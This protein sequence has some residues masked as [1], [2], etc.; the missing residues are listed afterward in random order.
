M[1]IENSPRRRLR[2]ERSP[3]AYLI[4]GS[5]IAIYG[6]GLLFD[7]LGFGEVRYYV[8]HA[9]P[10]ALVIIGIT[11]LIRRDENCNRYGFWGTVLIFGGLWAYAA[12]RGW[13]HVNFWAVFGPTMLV[14]LGASFVYRAL[15]RPRPDSD[16]G[17]YIHSFAIF[18]G[19]ELK[20]TTTPFSG[21]DLAALMGGVV[22]DL[23]NTQME[24]DSATIDV[25][26][27][28]GG[29][30]LFVPRDW[31]VTTKVM[32]FMGACVDKRRPATTP[33]TK[34]LI[35][36]GATFLGGIEIKD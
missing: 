22:L 15:Y 14:L 4:I 7:N 30:E 25:L 8:R 27:V 10:A 19:N 5:L 2:R 23:S 11:L 13:I 33:G 34:T 36:R 29:I 1:A 16:S 12:Q 32:S 21:A 20:P 31:N 17:S 6:L 3:I 18:S 26:S 9:W 24:S 35:V 28:M